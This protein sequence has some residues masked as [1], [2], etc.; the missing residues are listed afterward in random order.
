MKPSPLFAAIAV[1]LCAA[2]IALAQPAPAGGT[3]P[4][5]PA[6]AKPKT[7]IKPA[8]T[9]R[10]VTYNIENWRYSF[11]AHKVW[12]TSQ[13][14]WS[15]D[16]V[17]LVQREKRED[18]EENWEVART[19][20]HADVMPDILVIEEGCDVKDLNYFNTQFLKGYFETVHIFKSNDERGQNIAILVKP[21]FKVLEYK[22]DFHNIPDTHDVNPISD[23][24]FARGPAFALIEA[25][26]GAKFWVGVNHAKSK[27]GNS[28]PVSKWRL[29]EAQKTNEIIAGIRKSGPRE[30]VFLGDL[31][32]ELGIQEFEKDAGGSS[33][34]AIAGSGEN[35][36]TIASKKLADEGKISFH[37]GR[38][39][40]Y[41]SFI[42][43]VFLT[44][45]ASRRLTNVRIFTGDLADVASDHYPVIVEMNFPAPGYQGP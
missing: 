14:S 36:L 25:A 40:R 29:A 3:K 43:H 4:R 7:E 34:E 5:P 27:S 11:L 32:D 45:E 38:S 8:G 15:E 13:P 12:P 30:V 6:D 23:K 44:P 26:N 39:S 10:I 28:V 31:N 1:T 42:D 37:G 20:L 18:D 41:R 21:G 17:D 33:I 22:E 16:L 24:L 2:G 9:V 35:Q 19:I